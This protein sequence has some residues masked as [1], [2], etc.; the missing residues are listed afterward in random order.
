MKKG[1]THMQQ[2]V[3]FSF[4]ERPKV[5]V[6]KVIRTSLAEIGEGTKKDPVRILEQYWSLD[7]KLLWEKDTLK[8]KPKD[9][10]AIK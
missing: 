5:E 7:G 8:L 9:F 10:K 3:S 4:T 2:N 6:I 1:T